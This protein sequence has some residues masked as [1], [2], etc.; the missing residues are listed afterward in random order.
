VLAKISQA[1]VI[2]PIIIGLLFYKGLNRSFKVFFFYFPIAAIF[3]VTA[4]LSKYYNGHNLFL[5]HLF[6]P[7]EFVFFIYPFYIYFT[8]SFIKKGII[9]ISILFFVGCILNTL[10]FGML[11]YNSIPRSFE[12]IFLIFLSL[13]YFYQFFNTNNEIQVYTQPMFWLSS[14]I[15]IY[16][17]IDFFSFMMINLLLKK[18]MEM[19]YIS[20]TIHAIINIIGYLL[21]SISFRCFQKIK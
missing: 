6:I 1:S 20:K 9:V 10:Y 5:L 17:C 3:E 14:G 13:C 19:A 4:A 8:S 2:I 11:N 21:Y 16:F 7:I 15:L 18:D 12:S